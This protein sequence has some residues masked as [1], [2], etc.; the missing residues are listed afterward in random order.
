MLDN[1]LSGWITGSPQA[2]KCHDY[3]MILPELWH[4]PRLPYAIATT[5]HRDGHGGL[6]SGG[7]PVAARGFSQE[8]GNVNQQM[9]ANHNHN[10]KRL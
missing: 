5:G 6:C 1:W 4:H 2:L 7:K 9:L 3:A 10:I 8:L